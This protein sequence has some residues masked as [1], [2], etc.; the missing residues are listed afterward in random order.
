MTKTALVT[1]ANKGIGYEIAKNLLIKGYT[2]LVGSRDESRGQKAVDELKTFGDAKLQIIDMSKV[3]ELAKIAEDITTQHPDFSLLVN[4][5]GIA[6]DMGK[7]AW[8]FTTDELVETYTVDFLGPYE[9]S[10]SLLPILDKNNGQILSMTVPIEP[11]SFFHPFG[12]LAAKAPLNVMTK[13]WHVEFKAQNKA[14]E[15]FAF[16]PGGVTTDLNNHMAGPGFKTAAEAGKLTVDLITDD[17]DRSGQV[18]NFDGN[19]IS[20]D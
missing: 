11:N 14:I 20:Y 9:L 1:G 12:Y 3:N 16:I 18:I 15:I 8:E 10:R 19:P 6:G 17:T 5:A 2:V 7:T 4:N 13:N